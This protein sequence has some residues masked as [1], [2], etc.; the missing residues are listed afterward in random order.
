MHPYNVQIKH[1]GV[2][3]CDQV[4]HFLGGEMLV[5]YGWELCVHQGCMQSLPMQILCCQKTNQDTLQ[6]LYVQ[7][8]Q[9]HEQS[10]YDHEHN[11][12]CGN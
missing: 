8:Q 7:K 10:Q 3:Q 6:L 12:Q 4:Q 9:H 5:I 1:K 2:R 11:L